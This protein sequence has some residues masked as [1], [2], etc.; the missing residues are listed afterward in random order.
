LELIGGKGGG[1]PESAQASGT[2]ASNLDKALVVA[3]TFALSK[4][5]EVK[6]SLK[7]AIAVQPD[8]GG[9]VAVTPEPTS[10]RKK[11]SKKVEENKKA[12]NPGAF[13]VSGPK[14]SPGVLMVE[15]V[16]KYCGV[17][18]VSSVSQKFS[19]Y[20]DGLSLTSY[21]PALLYLCNKNSNTTLSGKTSEAQSSI[22]S[23]LFYSS[24]DLY[25]SVSGW[26]DPCLGACPNANPGTVARSKQDLLARLC[27]LNALLAPRT[28]LVGERLSLADVSTALS[29]KKAFEKVLSPEFRLQNRHLTRWYTTILNQPNI[30][31]VLDG[32]IVV[33]AATES[34]IVKATPQDKK[35]KKKTSPT[36]SEKKESKVVEEKKKPAANENDDIPAETKKP[37]PL[38]ALPKGTFDLE[39]WKRFYS[40]NEEDASIAYFWKNF[41][42]SCYSIWR[43]DYRYNDELTQIFMSCNLMGGMFQR[44]EKLKKNAFASACLFGE[45]NSSSIS[46]IWV[47]KGQQLAFELQEDWQVDF[48]SYDWVKLDPSKSETKDVVNQYWKWSGADKN[49]KKFNQG[50]IFK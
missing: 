32:N 41:D 16:A 45:N 10:K 46:S 40:N 15:A 30:L 2:N 38:D 35:E 47:F 43:G 24:G 36:A 33:F 23:W 26:V 12:K 19:F 21:I 39:D 6:V 18:L 13:K 7:P 49:G 3:E 9:D 34:E 20:H 5:S 1:K 11:E 14:G 31:E 29:L 28:Y 22:L 4:L 25:H 50:K 44:L 48:T 17:E 27:T 8:A 42:S 37:D